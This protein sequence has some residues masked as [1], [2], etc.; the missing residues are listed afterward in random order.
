MF[1]GGFLVVRRFWSMRRAA[2]LAARRIIPTGRR[3]RLLSAAAI[4]LGPIGTARAHTISIGYENSGPGALTFW[5]GTYHSGVNFNEG[6]LQ[7]VGPSFN[8]TVAFSLLVALKPAGLID[9]STN[10]YSNGTTL[11]GDIAHSVHAGPVLAWQGASF[12]GLKPGGYTFTYIPIAH[13]S[14]TWQPIDNIILSSTVTLTASLLG[15]LAPQLPPGTPA[16]PLNTANAIDN[17]TLGGGTLPAGFLGLA[18]LTPQQLGSA[19]TQLSGEQATG[20]QTGAFQVMNAFLS[21]MLNPFADNRGGGFGP[22]IGFAPDREQQLPPEVADAYASVLKAPPSQAAYS[23]RYNVW[24]AAFGGTSHTS[25]D[26]TGTGSNDISTRAGG[27]VVGLDYRVTPDT[28]FGFSLTGGGTSWDLANGLGGGRSDVFQAGVYGS[29]QFGAAYLSGALAFS[30]YWASTSRTVT[31]AGTDTLAAS[32]NAQSFG[33]RLE[34]GY[35]VDMVPFILT[36][37]AAAQAQTFRTPSYGEAAIAGSPQFALTYNAQT[38]TA[39]RSELGSWINKTYA[40]NDGNMLGLFGRAA[41]AHDWDSNP[42]LTPTFLGLPAVSFVVNGAKP[43]TNLA[44]LTAGGELRLRNGWFLMG[45]FDGEFAERSQ[46]YTGTARLRY[47][48]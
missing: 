1:S 27:F 43:P 26:Q 39:L 32:F 48:W 9:G 15:L 40:L 37:Y 20:A 42:S 35:R 47:M 2:I 13:P 22:A 21:L 31:V 8:S 7:V 36:P 3:L 16:N 24:G 6:S 38:A 4:I 17:F 11:I 29:R 30:N 41:W 25:G 10:F 34:S 12:S 46:T 45:K 14:A 19:L 33:G 5:Y 44:L 28:M 23:P 18:T